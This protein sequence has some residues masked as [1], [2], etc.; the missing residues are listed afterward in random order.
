M[1][2]TG[3]LT[4]RGSSWS[5]R[6]GARINS[7]NGGMSG[8][9]SLNVIDLLINKVIPLKPDVVV[10]MENINDL[11]TL[12]YEGTYWSKQHGPVAP[13]DP[14][15]A[16]PGGQTPERNFYSQSQLRL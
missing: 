7:Y 6:P 13:G 2:T 8:N 15:K 3:C 4:W 9:N 5:R 1:R 16:A 14:E 11:S 12:L 10:F